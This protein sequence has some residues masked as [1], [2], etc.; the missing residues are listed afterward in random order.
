MSW[1]PGNTWDLL[2]LSL[3]LCPHCPE[4]PGSEEGGAGMGIWVS[5]LAQGEPSH[6]LVQP[7]ASR[8]RGPLS[9]LLLPPVTQRKSPVLVMKSFFFLLKS[10]LILLKDRMCVHVCAHVCTHYYPSISNCRPSP[11]FPMGPI[12]SHPAIL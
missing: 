11:H 6:R 10:N 2:I 4:D 8:G 12:C 9:T 1:S 5:S 7:V 3:S